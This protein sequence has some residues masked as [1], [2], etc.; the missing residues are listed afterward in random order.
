MLT[1]YTMMSDKQIKKAV[2]KIIEDLSDRRDFDNIWNGTDPDIQQE[3]KD[4]WFE[5]LKAASTY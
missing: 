5:I 4:A 1:D 3:I 2:N